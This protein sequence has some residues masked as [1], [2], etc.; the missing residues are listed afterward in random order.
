MELFFELKQLKKR[1]QKSIYLPKVLEKVNLDCNVM[2]ELRRKA[3]NELCKERK[4]KI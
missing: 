1:Q 4:E 3:P 2:K